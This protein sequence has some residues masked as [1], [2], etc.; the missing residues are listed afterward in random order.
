MMLP[1]ANISTEWAWTNGQLL[2]IFQF[3]EL[4]SILGYAP[5]TRL[6]YRRNS[7]IYFSDDRT[8]YG[9]D[10]VSSFALPDL[11]AR[12]IL[13]SN[14]GS[15]AQQGISPRFLGEA[16]GRETVTLTTLEMPPHR[17]D[18]YFSAADATT[19]F[20][21]AGYM[22]SAT[23]PLAGS[24]SANTSTLSSSSLL[25]TGSGQAFDMM[26]PYIAVAYF[27]CIRTSGC[28]RDGT[29]VGLIL[30]SIDSYN[31]TTEA[32]SNGWLQASGQL[33]PQLSHPTL[34]DIAS[35]VN[36]TNGPSVLSVPNLGGKSPIGYAPFGALGRSPRP[37]LSVGGS[38]AVQLGVNHLPPHSH[39]VYVSQNVSTVMGS[40]IRGTSPQRFCIPSSASPVYL[41]SDTIGSA[42][43]SDSFNIEAPSASVS[44]IICVKEGGCD[45]QLPL[46]SILHHAGAKSS[47]LEAFWK[48]PDGS[49]IDA[50]TNSKLFNITSRYWAAT[51]AN[52][53]F[54]LPDFRGRML[55]GASDDINPPSRPLGVY[56]G[57]EQA[58]IPR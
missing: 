33:L 48:V 6:I 44:F 29:P 28:A 40:F 54:Q 5:S 36:L 25:T 46:G 49:N 20:P 4:F 11:R 24:Q 2:P 14:D 10:G 8:V 45:S 13:A 19:S 26:P 31:A 42:G 32:S 39:G 51:P 38:D 12:F 50:D 9:G 23:S 34:Y 3:L 7:F 53:T 1:H 56:F 43:L 16:E 21:T 35:Q 37:I 47:L 57:Q 55:F 58:R 52:G 27:I 41:A 15:N 17:H 30:P 18:F 22:M